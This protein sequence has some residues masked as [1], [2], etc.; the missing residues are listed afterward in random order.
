MYSQ[1]RVMKNIEIQNQINEKTQIEIHRYKKI[2]TNRNTQVQKDTHKYKDIL[3]D[4]FLS[5]KYISQSN[6]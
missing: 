3:P 1:H 4:M 6:L 5:L 2:H